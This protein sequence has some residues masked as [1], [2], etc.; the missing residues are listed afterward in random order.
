MKVSLESYKQQAQDTQR[1]TNVVVGQLLEL[2]LMAIEQNSDDILELTR[3]DGFQFIDMSGNPIE[4][5]E[6]A[7]VHLVDV[8]DKSLFFN[9]ITR[10]IEILTLQETADGHRIISDGLNLDNIFLKSYLLNPDV[11]ED[12][13]H[14]VGLNGILSADLQQ[15][16]TTQLTLEL[17]LQ[18][19]Q[20]NQHQA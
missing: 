18:R 15:R 8:D 14:V 12:I 5:V 3:T 7:H 2:V 13:Y 1:R 19:V 11:F 10:N 17:E 16:K 4:V 20:N 9:P 6:L